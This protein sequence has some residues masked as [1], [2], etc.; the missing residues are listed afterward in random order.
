MAQLV[1]NNLKTA[2]TG[3][4]GHVKA[5]IQRTLG[6]H[7]PFSSAGLLS[8]FYLMKL[9]GTK[10]NR[11]PSLLRKGAGMVYCGRGG[12]SFRAQD[13]EGCV[14]TA[15]KAPWQLWVGIFWPY[16]LRIA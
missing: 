15:V 14:H 1:N 3:F 9:S 2:G 11:G 4:T 10:H 6:S 7:I 13:Q 8:Q 5:G 12:D 16:H